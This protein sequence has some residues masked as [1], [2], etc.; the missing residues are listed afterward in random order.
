MASAAVARAR[1]R[2][3]VRA[4]QMRGLSRLIL[5]TR[6]L[7]SG[8]HSR[9]SQVLMKDLSVRPPGVETNL[10]LNK[11][12]RQDL[13]RLSFK[14]SENDFLACVYAR[15]EEGKLSCDFQD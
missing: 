5:F 7:P 11:T 6:S 8:E 1:E 2:N 3:R 12:Q 10:H 4:G 13:L 9:W 15:V 14:G